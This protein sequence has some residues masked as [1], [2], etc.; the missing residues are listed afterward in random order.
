MSNLIG[1]HIIHLYIIREREKK[2]C[3]DT[4]LWCLIAFRNYQK[5][6]E[7]SFMCFL[8]PSKVYKGNFVYRLMQ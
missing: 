7:K 3:V 6:K 2:I 8:T 5:G 1:M 4:L